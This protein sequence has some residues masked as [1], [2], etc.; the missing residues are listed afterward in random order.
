[1]PRRVAV[2]A[3]PRSGPNLVIFFAENSGTRRTARAIAHITGGDLFDLGGK[4]P[5]PDLLSYDTF[6]VGGSLQE[7]PFAKGRIPEPLADFLA[8]TD[9]IDGRVIPFWTSRE[10]AGSSP[11][12]DLNGEFEKLLR[13]GRMLRGGGFRLGRWTA[14]KEINGMA[15][16]WA[17]A[18]LAELGLRQ[19]AGGDRAEDMAKLFVA[20]YPERLGPA[21]F[22]DGDWTFEMDGERWQYAQ[23]RMLPQA[24]VERAEEFR[25]QFLYR[26]ALEPAGVSADAN[27]WQEL[28]D[29]ILSRRSSPGPNGRL[30]TIPGALR[31]PFYEALWQTRSREE[32]YA[33]QQWIAFLGR[34]VQVHRGIIAPLGR[35]EERILALAKVDPEIQGWIQNLHSITGWNWR[36][37]AGSANRSYHSYGIAVDLLMRAQPGMETY[38]QWTEAKGIDWRSV[39]AENRQSPP[40][41][42]IR[43]FEDQGFIW[44]GRWSRYDTMHFEYH[45]ELLIFSSG[46]RTGSAV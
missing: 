40:A 8:R 17:A 36:N 20:A 39:P 23:G 26:Y 46:R 2:E 22:Q 9:F 10:E 21:V 29:G 15:E 42:A 30:Y 13:G 4:K 32:A 6:F 35:A 38:W 27:P 1:V 33:R 3:D 19:A 44:G 24:D 43:I 18:P 41:A 11:P 7:G 12:G 16:T 45:P 5:L 28:A 25:P 34:Q 14:A 37:V 31:S